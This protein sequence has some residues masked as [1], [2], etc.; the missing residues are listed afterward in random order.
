MYMSLSLTL[1][2]ILKLLIVILYRNSRV[3]VPAFELHFDF[4]LIY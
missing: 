3:G 2:V 1:M 4:S